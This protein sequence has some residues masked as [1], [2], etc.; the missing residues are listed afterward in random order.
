[1]TDPSPSEFVAAH[2]LS[3]YPPA[4]VMEVIEAARYW[5]AWRATYDGPMP[6]TA[7]ASLVAAVDA[8]FDGEGRSGL[9]ETSRDQTSDK[10]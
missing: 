8:L 9:A 3:R 10:E 6:R 4:L 1:M 2:E 7:S 5:R